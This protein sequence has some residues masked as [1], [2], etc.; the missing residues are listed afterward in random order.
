MT[1]I[2]I[3]RAATISYCRFIP[4]SY[5]KRFA[6]NMGHLAAAQQDADL[7]DKQD[8][9]L[10]NLCLRYQNQIA[11]RLRPSISYQSNRWATI[12]I[13][14]AHLT[15]FRLATLVDAK[16]EILL[17]A[18]HLVKDALDIDV[19]KTFPSQTYYLA[20]LGWLPHLHRLFGVPYPG[21]DLDRAP[22]DIATLLALCG[23]VRPEI[24]ARFD[25]EGGFRAYFN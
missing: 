20:A 2:Q 9:Y 25:A 11:D 5:S 13:C 14:G 7:T 4:G 3:I 10:R 23:D 24:A 18:Y 19:H 8:A 16:I 17:T 22:I 12:S 15:T 1:P 6:R 21:E